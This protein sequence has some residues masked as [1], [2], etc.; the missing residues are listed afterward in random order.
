MRR[1]SGTSET[2]GVDRRPRD[3]R[4]RRAGRGCRISPLSTRSMPKSAARQL[5]AAA[6]HQTGEP[7]DLA[8]VEVEADVVDA[9][10]G[11]EVAD[12]RAGEPPSD[13]RALLPLEG[14]LHRS[15]PTMASM[16][17][18]MVSVGRVLGQDVP[19]VAQDGD[20]VGDAEDLLHAVRDVDDRDASRLEP[21]RPARRATRPR[22]AVSD[23]VGSSMIRTRASWASAL[24]ISVSCQ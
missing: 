9:V 8:G 22:C 3:C 18:F 15:C 13:R 11:R 17:W 10:S 12:L 6:A 21:L 5:G 19:A 4:C 16:I 23:E 1:S 20:A 24:A 7:E 2:P 14:L